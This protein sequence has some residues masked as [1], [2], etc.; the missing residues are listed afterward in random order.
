[1]STTEL[2]YFPVP[3][4]EVLS[5]GPQPLL[6]LLVPVLDELAE[7]VSAVTDADLGRPTPCQEFDVAA[8]RDH[9]LGWLQFFAAAFADPARRGSRPDPLTYRATTDPRDLGGVVREAAGTLAAAMHAGALDG[10][11]AMSQARMSAPAAFGMVL[12]EYLV[13]GWD[14]A[15]ALDRPW[16]PPDE[17]VQ[18][19]LDFFAGMVAPEY[20]GDGGFFAAEVPV[21][22]DAAVLDRLI[23]FAGRDPGWSPPAVS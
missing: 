18:V 9:T 2:P 22:A 6:S 17:P 1:M 10:D 14:L 11:V 3:A 21:P 4:P 15:R 23:G 13:H 5:S 7:T 8:L 19:A 16:T 12:G 20:R